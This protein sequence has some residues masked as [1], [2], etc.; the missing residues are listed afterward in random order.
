MQAELDGLMALARVVDPSASGTSPTGKRSRKRRREAGSATDQREEPTFAYATLQAKVRAMFE[1]LGDWQRSA[2]LALK[3][4]RA[5]E[6]KFNTV[7][8]RALQRFALSVGKS[9]MSLADQKKLYDFLDIWDGTQPGQL[10]DSGH[11]QKLREV[12][13]SVG[14]FKSAL[15]DDIDAGVREKLW[16]KSTLVEGGQSYQAFFTP[17]LNVILNLM[18]EDKDVRLWSG[19]SGPAPPTDLRESVLD[20]D[21]FRSAEKA[22]VDE[23]G[24]RSCV[25]GI[26]MYSDSFQLSWSGGKGTACT[27]VSRLSCA[28]SHDLLNHC[29]GE[30][31]CWVWSATAPLTDGDVV[32]PAIALWC[33]FWSL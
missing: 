32:I 26:H 3:R 13:P 33:S 8:L 30:L 14:A 18:R 16:R 31:S 20:G 29:G 28:C 5:K 17:A 7:R 19:E 10:R 21:A 2:P 6:G 12:F 25:L 22:V 1:E 9:G 15:R 11:D 24:S 4:K 27:S 23:H